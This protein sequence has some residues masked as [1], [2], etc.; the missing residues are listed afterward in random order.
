MRAA[1]IT[2]TDAPPRPADFDDPRPADGQ[3]AVDV[4]LAGINPVDLTRA[5]GA[6]GEIALPSVAGSEGVAQLDGRRVYFA[7]AVAPHGSM[8]QRTLIDPSEV[9]DVPDGIDDEHAVLLGIAGLAAWL[10]LTHHADAARSKRLLVLGAT[11]IAGQLAVQGAKLLGAE[12]VVAAGRHEETLRPL[13]DRGADQLVILGDDP[14]SEL[15]ESAGEGFDL[16]VDYVFGEPMAAALGHTVV[17]GSVVCVGSGAG[18]TAPI[19]FR[20]L[21]ARTV[22]GH[23]NWHVP[24]EVRRDAYAD[25]ARHVQ[26]GRLDVE[27]ERFRLDDVEQAWEAQAAS[28]HAKLVLR[29]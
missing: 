1:V 5:S 7:T 25:M 15:A 19:A 28:P 24:Y 2:S 20:D 22:I 18:Q 29:P 14:A 11:G 17:H 27:F 16:V 12:H 3:V 8:A 13:L 21:Q 26:E 4:R 6:L 23:L 10:P 9:F